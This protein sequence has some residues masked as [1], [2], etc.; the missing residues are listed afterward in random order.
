MKLVRVS[1]KD[2]RYFK[3]IIKSDLEDGEVLDRLDDLSRIFKITAIRID[4]DFNVNYS[5]RTVAAIEKHIASLRKAAT[6]LLEEGSQA[7]AYV[8]KTK[9][10]A[11]DLQTGIKNSNVLVNK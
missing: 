7:A 3:K 6:R 8:A 1:K 2:N 11:E 4:K 9:K 10:Q 5:G